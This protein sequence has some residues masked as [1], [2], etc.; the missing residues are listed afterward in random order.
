MIGESAKGQR[1]LN[2]TNTTK[3]KA[4]E[5]LAKVQRVLRTANATKIK[6][7]EELA[8]VQAEFNAMETAKKAAEELAKVQGDLNAAMETANQQSAEELAKVQGEL[9]AMEITKREALEELAKVQGELKTVKEKSAEE[10]TR[11]Q[12]GLNAANTAKQEAVEARAAVAKPDENKILPTAREAVPKFMKYRKVMD[13][14]NI[15]GK[16]KR[17]GFKFNNPLLHGYAKICWS[18]CLRL[19]MHEI[20]EGCVGC[21][22]GVHLS[23]QEMNDEQKDEISNGFVPTMES[24]VEEWK[25]ARLRKARG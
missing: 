13:F 25:E 23:W 21:N 22:K 8:K 1:D 18:G 4:A 6:A 11:V 2:A 24:L 15:R 17:R 16:G 9:N 19:C 10:L 5:E 12:K 3:L 20:P 14:N 7:G